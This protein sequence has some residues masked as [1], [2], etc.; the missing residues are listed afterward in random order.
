M[1]QVVEVEAEVRRTWAICPRRVAAV[2]GDASAE[3]PKPVAADRSV[4][5]RVAGDQGVLRGDGRGAIEA[6][7][8]ALRPARWK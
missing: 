5:A 4:Y 7:P 8:E 6:W 3:R 1:R 2:F